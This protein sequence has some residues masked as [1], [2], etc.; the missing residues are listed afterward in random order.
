MEE[1]YRKMAL[2]DLNVIV[3]M[4]LE[5]FRRLVRPIGLFFPL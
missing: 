5:E 1:R 4:S 2:L 3:R